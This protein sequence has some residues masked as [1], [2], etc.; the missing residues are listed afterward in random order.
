MRVL[1][2]IPARGGSKGVP[3][4]NIYPVL[5][6]PLIHYTIESALESDRISDIVISS[7]SDKI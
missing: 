2:L 5:G 4:K 7:D 6:K 1:G 3:N